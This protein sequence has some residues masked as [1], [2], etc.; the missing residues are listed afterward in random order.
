MP[1]ILLIGGY[2]IELANYAVVQQRVSSVALQLA[3]NASRIGVDNGQAIYQLREG[4]LNDVLQGARLMGKTINLTK[5]GR[6]TLSSLENVTRVFADGTSDPAPVQ[7]IHWQR[8]IGQHTG[9]ESSYGAVNKPNGTPNV[10]AASDTTKANAGVV[11]PG[12]G[13]APLVKAP[14]GGAAMFVEVNYEY[15]PV[16]G[17]MFMDPTKIHYIASFV[18]RDKRDF[19]QIY[20]PAPPTGTPPP[21]PSTCDKHDA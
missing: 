5:Y 17:S 18:V 6:V 7:R 10:D 8:C 21:V 20:H 13:P 1:I 9:Y 2:G 19:A 11:S 15:Q 14:S 12:M 16:F 4:D 3:D